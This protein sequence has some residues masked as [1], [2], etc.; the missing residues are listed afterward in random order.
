MKLTPKVIKRKREWMKIL[1]V[2]KEKVVLAS[3]VF[4]MFLLSSALATAASD[5]IQNRSSPYFLVL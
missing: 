5:N 4:C 3:L 1:T 2:I